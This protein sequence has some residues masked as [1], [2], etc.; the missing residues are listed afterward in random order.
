MNWTEWWLNPPL[1]L[2]ATLALGYGSLFHLWQGR[3]FRDLIV[4][5]LA[6]GIGFGLGQ[7]LGVLL[8]SQW[9]QIG[10]VHIVEATLMAWFGLLIAR[11]KP[12][13]SH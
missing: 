8:N 1:V 12:E 13:Q 2:S 11:S 9:L 4:Y 5:V 3:T 7:G 10:Q 6:A